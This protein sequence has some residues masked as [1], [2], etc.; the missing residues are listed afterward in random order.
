VSYLNVQLLDKSFGGH[1]AAPQQFRH[2]MQM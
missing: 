2:A 1:S